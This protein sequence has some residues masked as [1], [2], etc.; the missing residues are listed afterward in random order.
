MSEHHVTTTWQ[1]QT[2]DFSYKTYNRSHRWEFEGGIKVNA[3]AAAEYQGD[4][5]LVDPEQAFTASLSSCHMLTFLAVACQKRFVI[6]SYVDNAVGILGKN[7]EGKMAMT[8]VILKPQIKFAGDNIPSEE[9]IAK[10]HDFAH[11][12]CFLA[13]SVKTEVKVEY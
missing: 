3:S 6:D 8:E 5:D 7:A 10:L 13:N 11:H 2:D 9:E 4:P 1:R 12:N